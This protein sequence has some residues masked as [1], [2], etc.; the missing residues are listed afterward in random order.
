MKNGKYNG[1][2]KVWHGNG[3][4]CMKLNFV[5]GTPDGKNTV[6][7]PNGKKKLK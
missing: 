1:E 3:H 6:Y 2:M 7:F 5:N 4:M